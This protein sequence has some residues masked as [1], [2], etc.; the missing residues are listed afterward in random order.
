M[1]NRT[2]HILW[3]AAVAMIATMVVATPIPDDP[4]GAPLGHLGTLTGPLSGLV[5]SGNGGKGKKSGLL[6]GL[7]NGLLGSGRRKST[8]P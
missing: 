6:S 7:L 2:T 3:L 1:I 8:K 4:P 5:P